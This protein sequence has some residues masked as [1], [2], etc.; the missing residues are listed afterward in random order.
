[1]Y[2]LPR[3]RKQLRI[4][5][6]GSERG[7]RSEH[8]HAF[9]KR[10]SR[11]VQRRAPRFIPLVVNAVFDVF[12][13]EIAVLVPEKL[14]QRAYRRI[15]IVS[16]ERLRDCALRRVEPAQK[17]LVDNRELFR[18]FLDF[19]HF[20]D[21]LGCIPKLYQKAFRP[22]DFLRRV[23]DVLS[24]RPAESSPLAQCV[25]AVFSNHVLRFHV[26]PERLAHFLL[27]LALHH[28]V[29]EKIL[30]RAF[31][32][33]HKAAE[34]GVKAPSA[35]DVGALRAERRRIQFL[36]VFSVRPS[37]DHQR[38]YARVYPAVANALFSH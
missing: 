10:G 12:K 8:F 23:S 19:L 24:C 31:A 35:D 3:F 28:A 34:Y 27:V 14:V 30:E 6:F 32:R 33:K 16:F 13:V 37:C 18:L 4:N 36:E 1:M 38:R 15:V 20:L 11:A 5:F 2:A 21:E 7:E 25:C 9:A 22:L 17:P 26:I 29:H